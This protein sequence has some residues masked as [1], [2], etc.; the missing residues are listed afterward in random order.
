MGNA[1]IMQAYQASPRQ[2]LI[3]WFDLEG[4]D[5]IQV[6][7]TPPLPPS[8]PTSWIGPTHFTDQSCEPGKTYS[9]RVCA[10]YDG[11]PACTETG[12]IRTPTEDPHLELPTPVIDAAGSTENSIQVHW[13]AGISYGKYHVRWSI[14][15]QPDQPQVDINSS[16]SDGSW[17]TDG[18]APGTRYRVI[19]QG[20]LGP[21]SAWSSEMFISTRPIPTPTPTWD[22][23]EDLTTTGNT[24]QTAAVARSG[25]TD[26][27]YV[28]HSQ[29][30]GYSPPGHLEPIHFE[31]PGS[32]APV[33][34][35]MA[36][37]NGWRTLR[38]LSIFRPGTL[39]SGWAT[40]VAAA[41]W[42]P[43]RIDLFYDCE[44]R[45]WH[46]Y[47]TDGGE[48]FS[49]PENLG[50]VVASAPAAV[51][52]KYGRID[53]FYKSSD[54]GLGHRWHD[55][56]DG[57]WNGPE[58]K[59]LS[60][61]SAPAVASSGP[62]TLDVYYRR[63]DN[64]LAHIYTVGGAPWSSEEVVPLTRPI[65]PDATPAVFSWDG[66]RVDIFIR[67]PAA[68]TYLLHSHWEGPPPGHWHEDLLPNLFGCSVSSAGGPGHLDL[69]GG[70]NID[71]NKMI[72]R[73][74]WYG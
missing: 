41:S 42:G 33:I 69:F 24:L 48:N 14:V 49:V 47:S 57:G 18:L 4:W 59:P 38:G 13:K 16:G 2:V 68:G 40:G 58:I 70:V 27:F 63:P 25:R 15:G 29:L 51:S 17:G 5:D 67:L 39:G 61:A 1:P 31:F 74:N 37:Q 64:R 52:S 9:Y 45:L 8:W 71:T 12:E 35:H 19:V 65:A 53:I 32:T 72:L 56:T 11:T 22:H 54:G 36:Y 3:T 43:R 46:M 26:V 20:C 73:H 21:C 28:A 62:G 30:A 66:N 10:I 60:V 23:S 6:S 44:A 34:G 7:R 55:T 50:D